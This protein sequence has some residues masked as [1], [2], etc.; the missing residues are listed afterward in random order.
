MENAKDMTSDAI[1]TVLGA[2]VAIVV[3]GKMIQSISQLNKPLKK[4]RTYN[5]FL[6]K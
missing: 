1:G 2:G 4:K 5:L 6:T 3:G